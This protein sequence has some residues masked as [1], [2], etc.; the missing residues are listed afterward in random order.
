MKG[1]EVIECMKCV[2]SSQIIHN[3]DFILIAFTS[4]YFD[5][6]G[7]FRFSLHQILNSSLIDRTVKLDIS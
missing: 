5:I 2:V 4:K 6:F 7:N 3:L 1:T